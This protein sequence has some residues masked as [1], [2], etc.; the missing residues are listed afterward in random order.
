[1]T[2]SRYAFAIAAVF[3]F[4]TYGVFLARHVE[5][6]AGG[7]DSS[8][9]MNNAR[10]LER[11]RL[12]IP[13]REIEGLST[14][15]LPSYAYIPLGFIPVGK[16]D[17]AP[18]YAMG[19]PL[20]I[21]GA[22]H[23]TGWDQ[24]ANATL[25]LHAMFSLLVL[26]CLSIVIGLSHPLAFL[27]ALFLGLSSIF[28][29]MSLQ[30]MSDVPA[31]AWCSFVILASWLS[32]RNASWAVVAGVAFSMCVLLRPTNILMIFPVAVVFGLAWKR[33]LW[34]L[35]G[36]M[37]G[38][39]FQAI[40]NWQLYGKVLATGYGD[41]GSLFRLE[42]VWPGALAYA[43]WMPVMLTPALLL[44]ARIP[45]VPHLRADRRLIVLMVW[46]A[47][48]LGFY[49]FYF[50]THE[51]WTY[52]RFMLPVFTAIIIL[53]LLAMREE[54]SGF[55]AKV[56]W[57]LGVVLVVFATGWNALWLARLHVLP[58]AG[59]EAYPAAAIWANENLPENA[60]IL[61]MQTTG[62]LLYYTKFT[63]V[64]F[65]QFRRDTFVNVE[66]A[67]VAA[68]RPIYAMLFPHETEEALTTHIP[69]RW[70]KINSV[71]HISIWRRE[72]S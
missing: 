25:W 71:R 27:G 60:V 33:W 19:L 8:G 64:R 9:Y 11:M 39:I 65:E 67:S 14:E 50:H 48:F 44:I 63:F 51:N 49:A 12:T 28:I 47:S 17:M 46:A 68:G 52:S 43:Q 38:A 53:M 59:E 20:L 5:A 42:Y 22:S 23:I 16:H 4:A 55:S 36:G 31:L 70:T 57:V 61:S 6:H 41:A 18:T 45:F 34:F 7:S 21:V 66:H 35:I 13:R 30:T 1:M 62:A 40:V 10:L 26:Y 2:L 3:V 69:G 56:R 24:A 32:R 54:F 29:C 58:G 15:T 37:P 72:A